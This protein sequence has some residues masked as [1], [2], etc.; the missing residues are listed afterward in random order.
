MS[1]DEVPAVTVPS[2]SKAGSRPART[3]ALVPGADAAVA[4]HRAVAGRDR[5]HLA[6]VLAV[7]PG[8][9]G[10]GVARD[11]QRL[12]LLARDLVLAGEVLGGLAHGH[13]GALALLVEV[14]VG[15]R[16]KAAHGHAAHGF[17]AGADERLAGIHADR[18]GSDVDRLHRRAAE[19]VDGGAGDRDR[20]VRDER[21]DAAQVEALLALGEGA[22]D[23]QVLDLGGID[24]G[25]IDQPV[26]DLGRE[27]VRALLHQRALVGE[28]EGANGHSRQ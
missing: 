6:G 22:A 9:G 1:G 7:V 24:A 14:G 2:A 18:T 25:L 4:L 17:D 3:S 23:D 21:H 12:L 5:N 28:M 16:V 27:I 15:R 20:Q 11:R 19:A 26:H 8:G 10:A 13:V